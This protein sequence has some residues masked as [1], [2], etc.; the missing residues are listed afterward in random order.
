VFSRP[1]KG[2]LRQAERAQQ[3]HLFSYLNLLSSLFPFRLL[4][5]ADLLDDGTETQQVKNM[6]ESKLKL[7]IAVLCRTSQHT[8]KLLQIAYRIKR[9][10]KHKQ[11]HDLTVTFQTLSFQQCPDIEEYGCNYEA[12]ES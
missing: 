3:K 1:V 7:I 12:I 6:L 8:Q 4:L 11:Q 9:I 5:L 2:I 10:P